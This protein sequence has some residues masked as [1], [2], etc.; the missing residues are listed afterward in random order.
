MTDYNIERL[1]AAVRNGCDQW[2]GANFVQESRAEG[3]KRFLKYAKRDEVAD[4][5]RVGD[6]VERHLVDG[7]SVRQL[8]PRS[9]P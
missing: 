7:E 3:V 9:T 6:T 4:R 1:R 5:L 2:P 8:L